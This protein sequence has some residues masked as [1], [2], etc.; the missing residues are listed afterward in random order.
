MNRNPTF[1]SIL[2]QVYG[3]RYCSTEL[4]HLPLDFTFLAGVP[5]ESSILPWILIFRFSE[6]PRSHDSSATTHVEL[7]TLSNKQTA[8]TTIRAIII[9]A[10]LVRTFCTIV[11]CRSQTHSHSTTFEIEL[12][13][14]HPTNT[15]N[16]IADSGNENGKA[17]HLHSPPLHCVPLV[18]LPHKSPV[19]VDSRVDSNVKKD[20]GLDTILRWLESYLLRL[21][22]CRNGSWRFWDRGGLAYQFRFHE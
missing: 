22:I 13:T 1:E 6:S 5:S 9:L 11:L 17:R 3:N 8:K 12:Q 4:I 2:V 21:P 18:L 7:T 10:H 14:L 20:S 19:W 15:I 16:P